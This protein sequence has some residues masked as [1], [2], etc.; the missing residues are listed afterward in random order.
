M[1]EQKLQ[2]LLDSMGLED[3]IG[4]LVQLTGDCFTGTEIQTG[5]AG[6]LGVPEEMVRRTGSILN[7]DGSDKLKEV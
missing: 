6:E 3:K 4:Q 1:T 2:E 7:V 5:P